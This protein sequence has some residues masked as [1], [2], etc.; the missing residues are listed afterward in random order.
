MAFIR[1]RGNTTQLLEAWRT[2]DSVRQRL[3][4]NCYGKDTAVAAIQEIRDRL[5]YLDCC[6]EWIKKHTWRHSR[7]TTQF[8]LLLEGG[9]WCLSPSKR[10]IQKQR[11]RL[12]RDLDALQKFLDRPPYLDT[13]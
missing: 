9:G 10:M 1:R 13:L 2:G 7:E 3:I 8:V 12:N 11:Q 4:A 6:D 5:K